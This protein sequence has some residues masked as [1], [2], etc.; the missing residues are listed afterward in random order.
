MQKSFTPMVLKHPFTYVGDEID[1]Y[2][3]G[4]GSLFYKDILI[5]KGL[6]LLDAIHTQ[7]N[8]N[9]KIFDI[10]GN[11]YYSGQMFFG[12]KN[13]KG[14]IY[15]QN[16]H[17]Y[18]HGNFVMDVAKDNDAKLYAENG[19][20]NYS[21]GIE[22]GNKVGFGKEYYECGIKLLRRGQFFDN[23]KHGRFV[24]FLESGVVMRNQKFKDGEESDVYGFY[25]S[26][27]KLVRRSYNGFSVSYLLSAGNC[28]GSGIGKRFFVSYGSLDRK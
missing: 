4:Y 27:G 6:F 3:H 25:D 22:D 19:Y 10:E 9:S 8:E 26:R 14:K 7:L 15:Y 21:G 17:V 2:R 12:Y 1:G 16:G 11:L 5:Y 13:G 23:E 20:Q 24:E 18:Y 28:R